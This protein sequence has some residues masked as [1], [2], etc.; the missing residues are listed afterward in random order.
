MHGVML[1][2]WSE[3]LAGQPLDLEAEKTPI[4]LHLTLAPT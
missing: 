3:N 4:N 1:H 2:A